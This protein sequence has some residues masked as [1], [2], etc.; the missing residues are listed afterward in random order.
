MVAYL[1]CRV[2][3]SSG[4]SVPAMLASRFLPPE[5]GPL[6]GNPGFGYPNSPANGYFYAAGTGDPG[7]PI[8][9]T[10]TDVMNSYGLLLVL[11]GVLPV[12][13]IG[14]DG[15]RGVPVASKVRR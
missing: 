6:T 12:L 13:L 4:V 1:Y 3:G 8:L 10:E 11:L 5:I 9:T 2:H 14:R 7:F 15:F